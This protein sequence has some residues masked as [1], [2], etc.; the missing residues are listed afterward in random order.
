M[1]IERMLFIDSL[2]YLPMPL[3]KLPDTFGISVTKSWYLHYFNN[4]T[5]LDCVV[6]FH[7]ISYFAANEMS[8]PERRES[9]TW[10]DDQKNNVFDNRLM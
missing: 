7:Y 10:Y 1:K 3:R 8:P 6:P 5:N 2:S 9:M 4:K